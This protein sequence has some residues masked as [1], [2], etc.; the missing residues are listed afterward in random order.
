MRLCLLSG[1][2]MYNNPT[3]IIWMLNILNKN[4]NQPP[5]KV[6]DVFTKDGELKPLKKEKKQ[7]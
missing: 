3:E 2:P 5:I 7:S 1:T 4:N 6:S